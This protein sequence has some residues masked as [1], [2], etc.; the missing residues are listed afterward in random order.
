VLVRVRRRTPSYLLTANFAVPALA[1]T[2]LLPRYLTDT[3]YVP[4]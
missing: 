2:C 4:R 1:L 3:V